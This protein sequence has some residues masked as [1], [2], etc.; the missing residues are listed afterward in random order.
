MRLVLSLIMLL[1]FSAAARAQVDPVYQPPAPATSRTQQ[2]ITMTRDLYQRLLLVESPGSIAS[3]LAEILRRNSKPCLAV[4]DFQ[5]IYRDSSE[6]RVKLKCPGLP[7]YGLAINQGGSTQVFGGDGM[8]GEFN[9]GSGVIHAVGGAPRAI[10]PPD[11][12]KPDLGPNGNLPGLL[13]GDEPGSIPAWLVTLIIVNGFIV[14]ALILS[15]FWFMRAKTTPQ[16]ERKE[17]APDRSSIE[18][19]AM[20]IESKE[21]LPDIFQ[22]PDGLFL[23]RG[24]RGKRRLFRSLFFAIVYRDY[25]WKIREVV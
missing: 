16:R 10:T 2:A 6:Q 18:K 8:V 9:A 24:K 22:H 4:T 15:F 12:R 25:G 17:R 3:T 7:L 5:V 20:V 1:G 11:R 14:F 13:Q 19:D 21:I 23:A